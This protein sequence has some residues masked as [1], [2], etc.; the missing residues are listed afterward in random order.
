MEGRKKGRKNDKRKHAREKRGR[1][2]G[3]RNDYFCLHAC[4]QASFEEKMSLFERFRVYRLPMKHF[5][6]YMLF[7]VGKLPVVHTVSHIAIGT[8]AND[9]RIWGT[10]QTWKEILDAISAQVRINGNAFTFTH[11]DI[12][13]R[14]SANRLNA[15]LWNTLTF[16]QAVNPIT[17]A[18]NPATNFL[19]I[20]PETFAQ[21]RNFNVFH[22]YL[23]RLI[24]SVEP[25]PASPTPV[26][27]LSYDHIELERDELIFRIHFGQ[28]IMSYYPKSCIEIVAGNLTLVLNG[29]L[30]DVLLDMDHA[31]NYR[32]HESRLR[33]GSP[34]WEYTTRRN[35]IVSGNEQ[36]VEM[37]LKDKYGNPLAYRICLL[38]QEMSEDEERHKS[39]ELRRADSECIYRT[40][41]FNRRSWTTLQLAIAFIQQFQRGEFYGIFH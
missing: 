23:L 12:E 29:Y 6:F 40:L 9:V 27:L 13:V 1:S 25:Q 39:K 21:L 26:N 31:I 14:A 35:F 2:F 18:A 16:S 38:A 34:S 41:M 24:E 10:F 36:I 7:E 33:P 37:T 19:S 8:D 20:T 15:F 11:A 17:G 32:Q 3:K 30:Q 5:T 22:S 28:S 4:M